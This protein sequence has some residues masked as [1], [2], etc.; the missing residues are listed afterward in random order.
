MTGSSGKKYGASWHSSAP[1]WR[2]YVGKLVNRLFRVREPNGLEKE[3]GEAT[4][5]LQEKHEKMI[6]LVE[7]I[8]KQADKEAESWRR[9]G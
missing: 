3:L 4:A 1:N 2:S 9:H 8:R 6:D 5:Q 7:V